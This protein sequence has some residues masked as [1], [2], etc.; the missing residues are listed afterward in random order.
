[1]CI[2]D[3]GLTEPVPVVQRAQPEATALLAAGDIGLCRRAWQMIDALEQ[4][5]KRRHYSTNENCSQLVAQGECR[6]T[7]LRAG[8]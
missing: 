6:V 8:R 5:W 2:R 7:C 3:S 1:M 4:D